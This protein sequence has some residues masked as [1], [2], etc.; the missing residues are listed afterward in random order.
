MILTTEA[1]KF[2]KNQLSPYEQSEILGYSELWFL[3]LEA[4]KLNVVPEKFSKTSFD[5]EHGSYMK[6]LGY[7]NAVGTGLRE[8]H[9][10]GGGGQLEVG[11]IVPGGKQK[12]DILQYFVLMHGGIGFSNN[13]NGS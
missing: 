9:G 13:S 4:K 10:N 3:G 1:L 11:K 8:R 2:F 12:G 7:G 6:V 5:D